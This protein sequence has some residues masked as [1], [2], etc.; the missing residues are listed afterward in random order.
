MDLCRRYTVDG[1]AISNE[2]GQD[3][4]YMSVQQRCKSV[5]AL[6][7]SDQSVSFSPEETFNLWLPIECI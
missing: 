3:G 7:Q 4:M 1:A 6:A 2:P 5:W